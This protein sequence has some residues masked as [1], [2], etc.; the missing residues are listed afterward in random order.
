MKNL[1][2]VF[3]SED[4]EQQIVWAEVYAPNIPDT[5]G[6]FMDAETIRKMAYKFMEDHKQ[7]K[8][9]L[10]HNNRLVKGACMVESFIARKDDPTFIEGSWVAGIHVPDKAVWHAI[11]SGEI[12]GFSMEAYVHK[13]VVELEIDIPPIISGKTMKHEDGH[14]H[15]FDVAYDDRGNFLGGRTGTV[16]GHNHIIKRGTV[17]EVEN[18]HNHRFSFVDFLNMAAP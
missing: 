3:K 11:K 12:N 1:K 4:D 6:E 7:T 13:R 14:E 17:T 16:N 10:R 18:G 5:D 9:D 8:I 2:A 15:T